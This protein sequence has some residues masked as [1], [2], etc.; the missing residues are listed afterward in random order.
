MLEQVTVCGRIQNKYWKHLLFLRSYFREANILCIFMRLYFQDMSLC[1]II[2]TLEII[3]EYLYSRLY[4]L[5]SLR[6][7]KVLANK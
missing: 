3:G 4:A 6:E 2:F 1:S 5:T 7:N